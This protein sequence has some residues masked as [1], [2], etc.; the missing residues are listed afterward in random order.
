MRYDEAFTVWRYASREPTTVLGSY[1]LPN[2]H[3]LHTFLVWIAIQIGG[4]DPVVV[5]LPA[6][7]AGVGLMPVAFLVSTRLVDTTAGLLAAALVAS[8]STLIDYSVNARG[9]TIAALLLL[10][11][12][13]LAHDIR[14]DRGGLG[15]AVALGLVGALGLWTVPVFLYGWTGTLLWLLPPGGGRPPSRRVGTAALAGI[16]SLG[17]ALVLYA[18][19]LVREGFESLVGNRFL[20]PIPLGDLVSGVPRLLGDVAQMWAHSL[21]VVAVVVVGLGLAYAYFSP[22]FPEIRWLTW[23]MTV[24]AALVLIGQRVI[25]FPRNWLVLLPVVLL[26]AGCGLAL[27]L[28]RLVPALSTRAHLAAGFSVAVAVAL[29]AAAATSDG[30]LSGEEPGLLDAE[31]VV[32]DLEALQQE[33]DG[34]VAISPSTAPLRYYALLHGISLHWLDPDQAATGTV[35]LVTAQDQ[36]PRQVLRSADLEEATPV[37]LVAEY[38]SG[39]LW[40]VRAMSEGRPIEP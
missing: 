7:I 3:V 32:L 31:Q 28:N 22:G 24:G 8:S 19:I 15:I 18:P 1:S 25:P 23:S 14:S 29:I 21:P 27:G 12:V 16:S 35:Y 34:L 9:Y 4:L 11:S 17:F 39:A 36:T 13:G 33:G 2:N 40:R 30:D 38:P 26:L 20:A 37:D 10:V 6:L 5:R